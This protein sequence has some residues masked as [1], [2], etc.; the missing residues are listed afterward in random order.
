MKNIQENTEDKID[1]NHELPDYISG[2]LSNEKLRSDIEDRIGKDEAFRKE[3]ESMRSAMNF[4][5]SAELTSPDEVYFANLQSKILNKTSARESVPFYAKVLSYWKY[6]IPAVTVCIVILVYT[7]NMNNNIPVTDLPKDVKKDSQ[8]II[9]PQNTTTPE[10][11]SVPENKDELLDL[12]YSTDNEDDLDNT[13]ITAPEIKPKN[14]SK[15]VKPDNILK[16]DASQL[17]IDL[18]NG[19]TEDN[20]YEEEYKNLSPEEQKKIIEELKKI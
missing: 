3:Y 10:N 7:S 1:L 20:S 17:G 19:D 9:V 12:Y 5:S 16:E 13:A 11:I 8:Q 2:T 4:L 6:L 18:F 15:N 14:N